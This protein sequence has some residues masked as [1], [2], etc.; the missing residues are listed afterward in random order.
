MPS[1][2]SAGLVLSRRRGSYRGSSE[3]LPSTPKG[4]DIAVAEVI[5]L[6]ICMD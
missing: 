6:A 2:S 1:L 3:S 5:T 4:L